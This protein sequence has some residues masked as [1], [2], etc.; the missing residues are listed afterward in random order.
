[1]TIE[2]AGAFALVSSNEK[3]IRKT[4]AQIIINDVIQTFFN[5]GKIKAELSW[6]ERHYG[7]R[8]RI[9]EE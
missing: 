8:R 6:K 9:N 2:A 3:H 1:M 4:V 7:L 5:C